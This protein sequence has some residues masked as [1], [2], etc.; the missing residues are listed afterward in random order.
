MN[1]LI[2]DTSSDIE[3]VALHDGARSFVRRVTTA[4]SHSLTLIPALDE[5]LREGGISIGEI[6]L[7]AVGTGPGSFTGVRIAVSTARMLAQV[8][9]RP[10]VGMRSQLLYAASMEGEPGI[11]LLVAFDAK[12]GRVFGALYRK[13][14]DGARPEEIIPPGDYALDHLAR[15]IDRNRP[16]IAAGDGIPAGYG[17]SPDFPRGF[18]HA[19]GLKFSI[20]DIAR[21]AEGEFEKD[22]EKSMNVSLVTPCYARKSDAEMALKKGS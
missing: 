15:G 7:F 1:I 20:G 18:L 12:K 11:N 21:I 6:D 16:T 14:M 13:T 5:V 19:S 4:K 10:I 2:I 22:R 17:N 3:L 8:T 9:G